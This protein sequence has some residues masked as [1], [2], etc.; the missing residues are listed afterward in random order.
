MSLELKQT[1]KALILTHENPDGDTLGSACALYEAI[2][3]S[4]G[5]AQVCTTDQPQDYYDFLPGFDKIIQVNDQIA[6]QHVSNGFRLII[7]DATSPERVGLT[8][9]PVEA[10]TLVIDHHPAGSNDYLVQACIEPHAS[11]TA[12]LLYHL[13]TASGFA[14]TEN[15][16]SG[17]FAGIVTD[18]GNF[19]YPNVTADTMKVVGKLIDNGLNI[20]KYSSL[21]YERMPL[22]NRKLLGKSMERLNVSLNGKLAISAITWDDMIEFEAKHKD[23][24]FIIDELRKLNGPEV[25]ILGKEFKPS[26]F[27]ISMRGRG[28]IDL[29]KVANR[30]GGGGHHDASGFT[31]TGDWLFVKNA[32]LELFEPLLE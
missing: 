30:F 9:L 6:A 14:M 18:T 25:Y 19:K 5:E 2:T 24:D 4:G 26:Q 3:E 10:K 8:S 7:V 11:S 21:I 20:S 27:R 29:N 22:S 13:L 23:T 32:L 16:M 12:E 28:R 31:T 15:V 1:K 17:I